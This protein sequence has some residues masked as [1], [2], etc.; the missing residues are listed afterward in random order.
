LKCF[1]ESGFNKAKKG[2]DLNCV[3]V[4]TRT[5]DSITLIG[6][7]PL[8]LPAKSTFSFRVDSLKNPYSM[9]PE[10]INIRT[11]VGLAANSGATSNNDEF[12]TGFIDQSQ[13]AFQ[14]LVP[15][16]IRN[17]KIKPG[18]SI[19]QENNGADGAFMI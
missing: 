1:A 8:G 3:A 14:P 17:I 12:F 16:Q 7:F 15:S 4:K 5:A 6:N 18:N 9:T 2:D 13:P 11:Y 10:T 19:V